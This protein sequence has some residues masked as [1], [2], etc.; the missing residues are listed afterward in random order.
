MK[1]HV[2]VPY[3]KRSFIPGLYAKSFKKSYFADEIDRMSIN[4]DN[5]TS[6]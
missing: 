2:K 6:E 4:N 5:P 3:N 1:Y